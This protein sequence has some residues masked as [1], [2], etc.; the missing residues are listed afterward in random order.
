MK[1]LLCSLALLCGVFT[2]PAS[3]QFS[4]SF[5]AGYVHV[6]QAALGAGGSITE[7]TGGFRCLYSD[8]GYKVHSNAEVL[9]GFW[10]F[11][12]TSGSSL[13]SVKVTNY[14]IPVFARFFLTKEKTR[15]RAFLDVGPS[16]NVLEA[17]ASAAGLSVSVQKDKFGAIGGIGFLVPLKRASLVVQVRYSYVQ[18]QGEINASTIQATAGLRLGGG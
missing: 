1:W 5:N 3:A 15:P 18:K 12:V 8:L 4:Y 13:G 10:G 7:G 16:I 2:S 14:G 6:Q 9:V 11:K 17:E